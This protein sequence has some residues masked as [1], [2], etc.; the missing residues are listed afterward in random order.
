MM[1]WTY[2]PATILNIAINIY[3]VPRYGMF[4][5]AWT[6]LLCQATT[7]V[8]AWFLGTSLFPVWLP[9][10]QVIRCILAIVPMALALMIVRFPLDW[11]GLFA[12]TLMGGTLY[13]IAAVVLDVGDVRT[14]GR[15]MLRKRIQVQGPGV[16][17]LI[18]PSATMLA[19][20]A[21]L[22][23]PHRFTARFSSAGFRSRATR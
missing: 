11:F 2:L 18:Q 12:A 7:V 13:V 3:V 16:H 5:A 10:G 23:S 8:G 19:P 17:Q 20:Q 4:G 15:S 14:L 6:A 22:P 9:I 1:L 21:S